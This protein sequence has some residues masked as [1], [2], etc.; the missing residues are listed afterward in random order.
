RLNRDEV[1]TLA[2]AALINHFKPQYNTLL[3]STNFAAQTHKKIKPL[4]KLLAKGITGL[5]VEICSANINARL[6][7][8]DALP[9]EPS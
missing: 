1:V 6:F 4:K 2:E 8:R 9:L 7:T 3:K 5:T